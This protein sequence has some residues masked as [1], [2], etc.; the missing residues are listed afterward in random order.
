M[1]G[2]VVEK[3]LIEEYGITSMAELDAAI[4][5]LKKIKIGVFCLA[6]QTES[7]SEKRKMQ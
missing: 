2:K 1:D 3:I 5:E 4:S 7:T 6:T